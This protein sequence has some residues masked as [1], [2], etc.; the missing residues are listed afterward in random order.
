MFSNIGEHVRRLSSLA[1]G[2]ALHAGLSQ[3][4]SRGLSPVEGIS[5]SGTSGALTCPGG[6]GLTRLEKGCFGSLDPAA[7]RDVRGLDPTELPPADKAATLSLTP[8]LRAR[9]DVDRPEAGS[10]PS[11]AR[12]LE[13]G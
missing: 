12:P 10:T 1:S 8:R 6:N 5:G 2:A 13:A 3:E 7:A 11:S 4:R 9:G